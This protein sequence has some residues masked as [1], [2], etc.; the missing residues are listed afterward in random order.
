MT[1]NI[2]ICSIGHIHHFLSYFADNQQKPM[3]TYG[4]NNFLVLVILC[5]ESK[6]SNFLTSGYRKL[7][8][9]FFFKEWKL[10]LTSDFFPEGVFQDLIDE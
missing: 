7:Y 9:F 1:K 2:V 5:P 10:R 3:S 6:T 8:F 4:A